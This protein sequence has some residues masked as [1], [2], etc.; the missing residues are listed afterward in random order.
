MVKELKGQVISSCLGGDGNP[1]LASLYATLHCLPL[2]HYVALSCTILHIVVLLHL[3]VTLH[4]L[5]PYYC[6]LPQCCTLALWCLHFCTFI[7]PTTIKRNSRPDQT[8]LQSYGPNSETCVLVFFFKVSFEE[9]WPS[10]PIP[11]P[12]LCYVMKRT[13]GP[14]PWLIGNLEQMVFTHPRS[15]NEQ[16]LPRSMFM[17][18]VCTHCILFSCE[19]VGQTSV[20]LTRPTKCMLGL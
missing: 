18:T 9:L 14:L 7:H 1:L 10:T 15:Q 2:L 13:V 20:A 3:C 6:T 8:R 12:T 11:L 4:R 19:L 16:H 5:S 17:C